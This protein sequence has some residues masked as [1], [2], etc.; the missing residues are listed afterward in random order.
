M[1]KVSL[2][3]VEDRAKA[4]RYPHPQPGYALRQGRAHTLLNRTRRRR[5]RS[6]VIP[7]LGEPVY[8]TYPPSARH[9]LAPG[10]SYARLFQGRRP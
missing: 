8:D 6:F 3:V 10:G 4:L 2:C 9:R 1:K 5:Q 7:A